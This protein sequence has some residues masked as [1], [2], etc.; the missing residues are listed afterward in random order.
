MQSWQRR[1]RRPTCLLLLC[2][3][4]LG[5][6]D[7]AAAVWP[8]PAKRFSG[9]MLIDAGSLGLA[10]LDGRVVAFGDFNGDQ[11]T[12]IVTLSTDQRTLTVYIWDHSRYLFTKTQSI[13]FSQNVVNV[14]AGDFSFDG[15]LDILVMMSQ[16]TGSWGNQ[17]IQVGMAV[18][19]GQGNGMF[20]GS[21]VAVP[22]SAAEEP[23]VL[24]ATGDI[25]VDL[26]GMFPTSSAP[27]P[28]TWRLW[29]NI[30]NTTANAGDMFEL[31]SPPLNTSKVCK[32]SNPHSS[33]VIDLD[34]DCLADLFLVCD[35]PTSANR[36]TYQIWINNK[37]GGFTLSREGD[38]PPGVGPITFADMDRDGTID[39]VFPTCQSVN[40]DTGVGTNCA[41]NIAYNKQIPTCAGSTGVIYPHAVGSCRLP[42]Q[43]CAADSNFSFDFT[44]S[45]DNDAFQ[46]IPLT[47][48]GASH[49]AN[50]LMFDP[51]FHP[52]LPLPIRIADTS[53]SGYPS[54]LPII[55]TQTPGGVLGIGSS[56]E[57]SVQLLNNVPCREGIPGCEGERIAK[58]RR[59][60]AVATDGTQVL[61]A[62]HDVRGVTVIDLDEDGTL[63]LLIQRTGTQSTT[64]LTFVQNNF[65][66]DA[67]FLKA[68]TLNG[69]CSGFC[70]RDGENYKPFGTGFPGASYKYT[71]LDT[72]GK[73][74]AAQGMFPTQ[75]LGQQPQTGY[76][77]LHTPYAYL[78][79]GRTNN[80][81]ENLFVGSTSH[82]EAHYINLEGVIPNSRL[83]VNPTVWKSNW[84]Y[85]LYLR[86][87]DWIPWVTVVALASCGLLAIIVFVL[88]LNEKREDERERRR[89]L[90]HINF[91]AL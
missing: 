84:E 65:F 31:T 30:W 86:P 34:G 82:A 35:S 71:I 3:L 63:D 76:H 27:G 87:G 89:G 73:R 29:Q 43:L 55:A 91:D 51:T 58:G 16:N 78:G 53:L 81:I 33:A 47:S 4:W 54:L 15:R 1:G 6:L 7:E 2:S 85:E 72:T 37:E 32:L 10:E 12:D 38:L 75:H 70:Q 41:I 83:V 59:A 8:F 18:Y 50:L 60:F 11:Y 23:I 44:N 67:F 61:K 49:S 36:K 48:L 46:S 24:D 9:D 88:H 52:P 19:L 14:V 25:K 39:L 66:H 26:L 17:A 20:S 5:I 56:L 90:H 45:P 22:G 21:P 62:I 57:T 13:P 28:P 79:L 64:K 74:S 69:A 77:A 80:Y 68:I 42:T 40:T